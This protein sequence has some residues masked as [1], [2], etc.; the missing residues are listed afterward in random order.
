MTHNGEDR[1]TDT[2]GERL[3]RIEE[4]VKSLAKSIDVLRDS[5]A[6]HVIE[7]NARDKRL[8]ALE[9]DFDELRGGAKVFLKGA[10]VVMVLMSGVWAMAT[11][12]AKVGN[13]T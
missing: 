3:A 2:H 12:V 11:W 8:D 5:F 1:R 7:E 13:P 9:K 4:G 10:A 6:A